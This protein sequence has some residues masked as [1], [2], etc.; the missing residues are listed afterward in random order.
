MIPGVPVSPLSVR[1]EVTTRCNARCVCCVRPTP[2][3]HM[4]WDTFEAALG[5]VGPGTVVDLYGRGE[6]TLHPRL[7]E[8]VARV[9]EEG[10]RPGLSTNGM[11]L[12]EKLLATLREAG[13][14]RASFSLYAGE[15]ALHERLQP[16]VCSARAWENF[17]RC[18]AT[19]L[20][21]AAVCVLMTDNLPTLPEWVHRVHDCGGRHVVFQQ[22]AFQ[23][24]SELESHAP[25][26]PAHVA[27]AR[28][29]LAAALEE[30][31]RLGV[32]VERNYSPLLQ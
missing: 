2:G 6:P 16:G 31:D 12:D 30:A 20:E 10:A 4:D 26:Q 22:L 5:F 9:T 17:A 19:G 7:P 14:E 1:I 11:L 13:L 23:P 27:P 8:M 18:R 3:E 32:R 28:S 24:G 21:G 29:W 15:P 25:T